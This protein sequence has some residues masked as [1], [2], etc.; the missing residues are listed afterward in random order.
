MIQ[1]KHRW[2][3]LVAYT[4]TQVIHEQQLIDNLWWELVPVMQSHSPMCGNFGQVDPALVLVI[5]M[6]NPVDPTTRFSAGYTFGMFDDTDEIEPQTLQVLVNLN[7]LRRH[8]IAE[9]ERI[10]AVRRA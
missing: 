9:A 7:E 8:A 5:D 10:E 4:V 2:G 3:D 6:E 1:G